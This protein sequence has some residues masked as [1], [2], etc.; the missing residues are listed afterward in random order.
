[1]KLLGL[2]IGQGYSNCGTFDSVWHPALLHKVKCYEISGWVFGPILSF[3]CNIWLHVVLMV[4]LSKSIQL[5]LEFLKAPFL[6]L[7]F[8]YNKLMTFLMKFGALTRAK[9]FL[10]PRVALYLH[11][12]TM[13]P[14]FK[15]CIHVCAGLIAVTW[16]C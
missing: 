4:G 6:T 13:Q 15:Y 5:L 9:R 16:L 10:P 2:L 11:I 7:H 1:M 3:F 8:S 12:S 14:C